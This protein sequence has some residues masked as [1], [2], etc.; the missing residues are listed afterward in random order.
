MK[1]KKNFLKFWWSQELDELKEKAMASCRLWKD[2]GKPR[3]GRMRD[4]YIRDKLTYKKRIRE[5]RNQE[6]NC[7]SNDLHEA[8][9]CKSG[10][11]FWRSWNSKFNTKK[12]ISQVGGIIDNATIAS[13]FATHFEKHCQPS[14]MLRN[15]VLKSKYDELRFNYNGTPIREDQA[16]DVELI[17]N[18]IEDMKKG[19][20][21]GLDGLTSEH[22]KYSHPILAVV[23]C[24]LFNLFVSHSHIPEIF[25][26]SY[27]VPIPKCDGRKKSLTV[28]DFRG[29]SIS[30]VLSKLF[31]LC[32]LDRYGDYFG[33]SD[34]QFGFKKHTSCSHVVYSVRNVIDH[35]VSNGSTI[36]VCTLDLSKAFDRM[37]HYVLFTKLIER[38]LPFKLLHLLEKWFTMSETCVRWSGQYS[39]FYKLTAGVRQGGVL[40]PFLFAI[41]IDGIVNKIKYANVGCYV[42]TVCV[43]IFLYADDILLIAP[44]VSGLQTLVNI[45]ETEL[46]Y[47]DMSINVKKS[48]CIRFGPRFNAKCVNITSA[49]GLQFEW[50]DKCRYLG[51]F[52]VSG[53]QFRCSFD[54]AKSS[55][56]TSFNSIFSKIGR[57][58]SEDVVLNLLRSKCLPALLYCVEAC[59]F[60]ERDKHSFDFSF[61]R[62]FMKLFRTGSVD[63]VT[64]CQKMFNILPLK[65]QVDIRTASFMLRFIASENTIC[66]LFVSHAARTLNNI[67]SRY[68]GLIDNIHSLKDAIVSQFRDS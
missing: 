50:V 37:N 48:V 66:H 60:F 5:E 52:F 9:Q 17:S 63:M 67:Y 11:D 19:K 23:I 41:F 43:S 8:L 58:A 47:V 59:P 44:S 55:F 68:G 12:G 4:I 53:R 34:Y 14:S 38:N 61:T 33:T 2:A 16:F 51:V 27:T 10:K 42:S 30:P 62:I 18:L 1:V 21:A 28:D 54:N 26:L 49:S 3:N 39:T 22:L 64:E 31:E 46:M 24:K 57:H 29:I 45:C 25:G 36:N 32:V 15:D 56:F 40:S 20:A 35:Y 6:I 13:N 7:F 65:Y